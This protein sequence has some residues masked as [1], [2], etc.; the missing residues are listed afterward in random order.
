ME[1]G[2][3]VKNIELSKRL[4]SAAKY[5]VLDQPIAD[6]GSDHAYLP[7]YLVQQN[8]IPSAIAGEITLGP[9]K[10]AKNMVTSYGLEEK[11]AVRLGN[12]LAVLE[13]NEIVGTIFI[14]GMGGLLIKKILSSDH[15]IEKISQKT[16][17]VLQANNEEIT[18]RKFLAKAN[19][20]I[21]A[22]EIL[23]EK[24]KTYEIIVAEFSEETVEYSELELFFGPKL[25]EA[26]SAIFIKKWSRELKTNERI[27]IQLLNTENEEKIAEIKEKIQKIKQV[28]S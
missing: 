10:R 13:K 8:K 21:V 26:A 4:H 25:L 18:L 12:G 20:E 7:L 19:Y 28:I 23:E 2:A 15:A 3:L 14:C 9:L 1:I 5:V 6:I 16:R 27:L 24:G 11:I 17:L 22:E